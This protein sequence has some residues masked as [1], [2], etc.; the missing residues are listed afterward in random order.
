MWQHRYRFVCALLTL[1]LSPILI[2]ILSAGDTSTLPLIQF[3]DLSYLGAF[4]LPDQMVN[5]DGFAIGGHPLAFNPSRNSL[6]VASR[7]GRL[8]EVAIPSLVSSND[9]LQLPFATLLQG[10]YESTEGTLAQVS[11]TD[12][13]VSGLLVMGDRLYGS[14]SIY[15]DANNIQRVSH[16]SRSTTLSQPGVSGMRQVW[17]DQKSGFVSGFMATV[18]N[19]WQ[20]ALGGPAITGQCCIPIAWRTSWGPSAFAFN[21]ADIN[22]LAKVPATPLLYY[23]Q[24]HPTLG[25][26]DKSDPIYGGT[27]QIMGVAILAGSRTALFFGRN[28]TGTWCY[29]NG[30]SNQSL[31]GTTGPDGAIYCYDPTSTAKAQHAYPYNYQIWAYDLNDFAAVRAGA[32]QP[33]E[34][35]P[36]GVWPFGLPFPESQVEIGGV[37]YDASRQ[38]LYV[39]Q[40]YAD[41]DGYGYRPIVHAL[42]VGAGA[43]GAPLPP[44][45][46]TP[47][48]PITNS[49]PV[50]PTITALSL[51]S[52]K[53]AP[54]AAGTTIRFTAT[55]TGGIGPHQ[56]KWLVHDGNQWSTATGWSTSTTFDWTPAVANNG[57]RLGVWVRSASNT[58]DQAEMTSS[59]DFPITSGTGTTSPPPPPSGTGRLTAV[60]LSANKPAP[61]PAGT[62]ITF[63]AVPTGGASPHQYKWLMHDG[64]VWRVVSDWTTTS[65]FSW[66]PASANPGYRFGVWVRSAGNTADAAEV[67]A[68]ADYPIT[69]ASSP[70]APPPPSTTAPKLTVV[71]IGANKAAPQP[72][73]TT[74]TFTAT[75]NGGATPQ[76]YKWL[77]HDGVQWTVAGDWATS[78]TFNWTPIVSN[79]GSRVGVWVRSAGNSVDAGEVTA[80]IDFPISAS[81]STPPPPPPPT[82]GTKLLGVVLGADKVAP[83]PQNTTITFTA[84]PNGGIAPQ[85]YKYLMHDGVQWKVIREWSTSN[86]FAWTPP[87]WNPNSR[88]GVWVRNAGNTVDAGEVT[89]SI[90][91]AI[92]PASTTS[93]PPPP[94]PVASQPTAAVSISA[95]RV[96]PQPPGTTITFTAVPTGGNAPHQYKFLVHNGTSWSAV[97]S[98][99]TANTFTWTPASTNPG[100]RVGVWVRSAGVS[101]DF[102]EATA[103]MDFAIK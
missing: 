38:I 11:A 27:T 82:G 14:A 22:S 33:W 45:D 49:T 90:D 66:T 37:G 15:Y 44:P 102:A 30:T 94:P 78:N 76:Q 31:V 89:A 74:I 65:S 69:A 43:V 36:Y 61:Q 96:A 91:Y 16:Y 80:S 70:P 32:K 92:S 100:Y 39:S 67:T 7:A 85:Q 8:A 1:F 46:P 10:F 77:V 52:N 4:R 68:S 60:T 13:S 93:P 73:G 19:E 51:T 47:L 103:S 71:T 29:G 56:Y 62:L 24:E 97:T 75:P 2:S 54:Q 12:A 21:P 34:V 42:K 48:P 87:A 40:M 5:G 28:G 58:A 18:P 59:M 63:S 3:G 35:R 98:W 25:R 50:S 64:L 9:I 86:T 88:I 84:V 83:Q 41:K 81:T 26:W 23:P 72:L 101:T 99:S 95:N 53:T 57:S 55:P 17:E 79:P 20:A 6:F